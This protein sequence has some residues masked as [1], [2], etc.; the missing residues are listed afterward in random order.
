MY[1]KDI[2]YKVDYQVLLL[3][4]TRILSGGELNMSD[5]VDMNLRYSYIFQNLLVGQ[6]LIT[7]S[8]LLSILLDWERE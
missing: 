1:E 5:G 4:G 2:H 8:N 3:K 6:V 7:S